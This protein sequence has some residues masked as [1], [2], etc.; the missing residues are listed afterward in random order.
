MLHYWLSRLLGNAIW[1]AQV[2]LPSASSFICVLSMGLILFFLL[3][4]FLRGEK[5]KAG[6]RDA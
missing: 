5:E 4:N 6:Q 3:Q 2:A 1:Y